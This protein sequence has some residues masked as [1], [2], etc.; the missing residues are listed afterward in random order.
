MLNRIVTRLVYC[1]ELTILDL[2]RSHDF[3]YPNEISAD[4]DGVLA[5]LLPG[6]LFNMSFSELCEIG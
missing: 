3:L 5:L 2:S 4:V 6:R 1:S